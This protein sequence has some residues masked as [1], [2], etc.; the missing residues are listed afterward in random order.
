M[1]TQII[2]K[3]FGFC[4]SQAK[5]GGDIIYF[6]LLQV[7]I[8]NELIHRST[9]VLSQTLKIC[10]DKFFICMFLAALYALHQI[11]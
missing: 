3:Y 1:Q 10:F 2:H 4:V 6:N 8:R 7:Q 11:I 9:N 5:Q